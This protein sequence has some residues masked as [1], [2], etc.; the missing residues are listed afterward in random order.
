M[1]ILIILGS[2]Y[3]LRIPPLQ[4]G[5]SSSSMS[6][7]GPL[8]RNSHT[9]LSKEDGLLNACPD[10]VGPMKDLVFAVCKRPQS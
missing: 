2:S 1:I 3:N 5:R 9:R 10:P 6:K 7:G 8:S 4:G